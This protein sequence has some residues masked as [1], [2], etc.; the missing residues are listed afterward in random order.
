MSISIVIPSYHRPT[1][2]RACLQALREQSRLPDEVIVG[3]RPGDD[4]TGKVAGECWTPLPVR[5]IPVHGNSIVAA[6]AAGVASARG[7]IIGF[8]DDD[9]VPAAEW[10]QRVACWYANEDVGAVGGPVLAPRAQDRQVT[11][12]EI[13]RVRP[14]GEVIDGTHK[15]VSHA[16]EVDHLRGCNMSARRTFAV[17]DQ[18]LAGYCYRW[19]LDLCLGVRRAGQRVIYDPAIYVTHHQRGRQENA[20]EIYCRQRNN[21][22]VLLKHLPAYRRLMFLLFTLLWGDTGCPGIGQ[23]L[24]WLAKHRRLGLLTHALLP[25]MAGKLAGCQRFLAQAGRAGMP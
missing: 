21:T 8:I 22:Y 2:L 14:W 9:A 10:C 17:F 7:E 25:G 15:L 19:E 23:Y 20:Y 16:R 24:G 12:G 5:L 3:A 11:A 13:C 1:Q 4:A 18:A 6:E